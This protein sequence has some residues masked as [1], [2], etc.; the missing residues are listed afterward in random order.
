[1]RSPSHCGRQQ[2][3]APQ[4]RWNGIQDSCYRLKCSRVFGATGDGS[5]GNF[6]LHGGGPMISGG[7]TH[8]N[9][10]NHAA[11]APGM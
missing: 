2:G 8:P 3:H 9:C 7:H 11:M 1:M 10:G 5:N 6:L 4:E